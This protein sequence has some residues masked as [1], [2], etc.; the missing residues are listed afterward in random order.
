[1]AKQSMAFLLSKYATFRIM[2][3][4]KHLYSLSHYGYILLSGSAIL[5]WALLTLFI[6]LNVL[7]AH[8]TFLVM[9]PAHFKRE[10]N[11]VAR[12][13]FKKLGLPRGI[14]I[15]KTVLLAILIPA[16]GFYAGNDLFTINIVLIV[17]DLVFILVVKHNYRVYQRVRQYP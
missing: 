11:P 10:R 17:C 15:F 9:R 13:V 14:I 2:Y 4:M 3:R 12:W 16:M 6:I 8:S 7:D 5:F 1:M